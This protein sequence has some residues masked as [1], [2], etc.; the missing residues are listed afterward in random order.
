MNRIA[1]VFSGAADFTRVNPWGLVLMAIG[2]VLALL[3]IQS[4]SARQAF[5]F[6][7]AGLLVCA[8]GALLAIIA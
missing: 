1:R 8:G 3:R 4:L 6:K 7:I 5:I 2:I